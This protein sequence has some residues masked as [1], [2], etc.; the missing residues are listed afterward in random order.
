MGELGIGSVA[1]ITAICYIIA[2]F[3]KTTKINNKLIPSL[4]GVIGIILGVVGIYTIAGF[5]AT[6][7]LNAAAVGAV[8]GWAA[9]GL[10]ESLTSFKIK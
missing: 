4:C 2:E 1:A 8:S 9:T 3:I 7:W 10:H 5:P 6:D